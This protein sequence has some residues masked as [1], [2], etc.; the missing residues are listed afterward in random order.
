M[1]GQL[2]H[3]I[4]MLPSTH[5]EKK[6]REKQNHVMPCEKTCKN[7][8]LVPF[9]HLCT[10]YTN[11]IFFMAGESARPG[12]K[13]GPVKKEWQVG[14][15]NDSRS[16]RPRTAAPGLARQGQGVAVHAHSRGVRGEDHTAA[17]AGA[18]RPV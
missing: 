13:T 18:D 9:V 15:D 16:R 2:L 6:T 5:A 8:L 11:S 14:R 1:E 12:K 17:A 3:E 4:R 10:D 7:E